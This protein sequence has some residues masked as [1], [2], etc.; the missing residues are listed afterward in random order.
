MKIIGVSGTNGSG[1]DTVGEL[2]RDDFGWLLVAVSDLMREE[3]KKRNLPPEREVLREISAEWRR[4]YELGVWFEKA[5]E[6]YNKSKKKY[7]GLV[8]TN[9]RNPGEADYI[10]KLGGKVVWV[11]ANPKVRF[12][13]VT[14]R[15]RDAESQKDF[16]HFLAQEKAEMS[17]SGDEATLN[18]AG[19]KDKA[20][21]FIQNN[22]NDLA[23]FKQDVIR[24]LHLN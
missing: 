19:V 2:L 20:D 13:R 8:I 5:V 1:K 22:G 23:A 3:A 17:H 16:E 24:A 12:E 4:K 9:A 14:K 10:H 7:S 21:I 18:M 11:D 6:K 15:A